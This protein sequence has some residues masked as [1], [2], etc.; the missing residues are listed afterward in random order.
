MDTQQPTPPPPQ[1]VHLYQFRVSHYNEKVRWAL[2]H[3]G[4]AHRRTSLIPGWHMLRARGLSG[5]EQLPILVLDERVLAGSSHILAEIERLRPTPPLYPEN[6][7]EH[8]RALAI[9]AFFDEQVA[10]DLRRLFWWTYLDRPQDC[11]RMATDGFSG[12]TCAVWRAC[13]PVMRPLIRRNMGL[14]IEGARQRLRGYFDR[15]ANEIGASGYLVG[16]RFGVADL[17]AAAVMTAIIR[18]PEF[19]YPLP[20]PW[21]PG[22]VALRASLAGHE[23]FG[24]VLDIYRRHRSPSS[25]IG[26]ASGKSLH[27]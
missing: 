19:S 13:L 9:Q 14:D 1:A 15:L 24:W 8:A 4:W 11:A 26:A 27:Y 22:L 3:K 20:E 2:D 21:P 25:E 7:A 12:A 6:P 23:A 10:P 18:P 16:N 17:S 5:Q